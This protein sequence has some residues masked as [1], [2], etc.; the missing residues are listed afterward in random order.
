MT[1]SPPAWAAD[2]A[3]IAA[4]DA[5]FRPDGLTTSTDTALEFTAHAMGTAGE[6]VTVWPCAE[7]PEMASDGLLRG[8]ASLAERSDG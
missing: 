5:R 1:G 4:A 7:L 6:G 2:L 8:L 3:R